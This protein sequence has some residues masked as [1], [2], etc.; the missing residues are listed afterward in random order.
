MK[1]ILIAAAM[2]S[3]SKIEA[4]DI[5]DFNRQS[6]KEDLFIVDDVLMGSRTSGGMQLSHDGHAIFEGSVSLEN[7][8][9]FSTVRYRFQKKDAGDQSVF[10]IRHPQ[11][12]IP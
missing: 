2:M 7:N 5:Y 11:I 12:R 6:T 9:G 4:L 8:G 10:K 3:Y 1:F